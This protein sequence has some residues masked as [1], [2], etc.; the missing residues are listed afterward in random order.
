[1]IKPTLASPL[2]DGDG[3][4]RPPSLAE[5]EAEV[6]RWVTVTPARSSSPA[7]NVA[8]DDQATRLRALIGV[9]PPQVRPQRTPADEPQ[10]TANPP[11]RAATFTIAVSSGKGGVGKTNI[12][13]NLA[14]ALAAL[15]Y[16]VTVLDADLGTA[17]ADVLCGLTPA[18][19][20][21]HVLPPGG[22]D[23]H[24]GARRTL[25]DIVVD[26][27]GGFRLIPG[28]AGVSRMADLGVADRRR[29]FGWLGEIEDQSDILLVD[30]AAGVGQ[31]V[32]AFLD[33]ADIC[34]VVT[35][36]EPT[37]ITDAYALVKCAASTDSRSLQFLGRRGSHRPVFRF[38][39]NQCEDDREARRVFARLRAVCARFLGVE[40]ALAGWLAQDVRVAEA[41]RARQLFWLRSRGCPAAAN[42]SALAASLT[43][44]LGP[45][46]P[47]PAAP[48]PPK[49]V[50]SG[51]RRFLGLA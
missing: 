32:T 29:L 51:L 42:I 6:E 37:A 38:I 12:T 43:Q 16:R 21:D 48:H 22:L 28:S 33:A 9:N 44:D 35:T 24:D 19:R 18:A 10:I 15:G 11:L 25:K 1:M 50:A 26:A 20:L 13:V 39:V 45:P 5:L 34:L 49:P 3:P 40:V 4:S 36:P 31:T 46:A 17:N 41:V 23:V 8:A 14:A 47:R 30:T 7:P 27:P 2:T